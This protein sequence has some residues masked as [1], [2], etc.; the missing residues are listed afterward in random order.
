[1][2][3]PLGVIMELR[4]LVAQDIPSMWQINYEGLPGTGEVTE[5]EIADL[6]LIS[7]ISI[8]IFES[9]ELLGFVLCLLPKTRYGSLNYAWFNQNYTDFIYVDRVAV[10]QNQRNRNIGS[11]LYQEVINYAQQNNCP[12]AAEVSLNPPNLGSMRFH[13]RHGFIEVGILHHATK[14]VTMMI[15]E[16]NDK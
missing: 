6:I 2:L 5:D 8:G 14:S 11:K 12:I 1:M 16:E 9:D 4:N 7:E 13:E 3:K 10:S 15:R